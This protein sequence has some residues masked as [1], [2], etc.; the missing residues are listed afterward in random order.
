M[1]H[2]IALL[3]FV[4]VSFWFPAQVTGAAIIIDH[5]CADISQIPEQWITTAKN[6][7]RISYGH[8]SHGSQL[9]TGIDAIRDFKGSPFDFTYSYGYSAEIFL[10]DYVP[11]GDLGNPDRTTWAQETR[12]FLNQHGN[13]RNVVMWSW[14]GQVDGTAAEINTYLTLMNQLEQDF[15][16]VRFVYMTGHL[17]GSGDS[18]NVNLRNEQI[19]DYARNHHKI[20]FDFADIESYDP[21]KGVNYM[22]LHCDDNCDYDSDGNGSLDKNWALDWIADNPGSE[23][24]Q[25]AGQ[26]QDC[27]H[28]QKL[29]CVL[30][31]GA[32]WWLMARLVGWDGGLSFRPTLSVTKASTGTGII[33]S[34]PYGIDCG[35]TCNTQSALFDMGTV[36]TL[37]AQ[38]DPY[39]TFTGWSGG[40]C[41]G[42][43]DCIVTLTADTTVIATFLAQYDVVVQGSGN[44]SGTV[45]GNGITCFVTDGVA[46]GDC[47]E[48][49]LEGTPFTLTATP[50]P[51]SVFS[52]WSGGGCPATGLCELNLAGDT[53][54][55]AAFTDEGSFTK[56]TMVSPNGREKLPSGGSWTLVWGGPSTAKSYKLSYSLD[57]GIT[58]VPITTGFITGTSM[59]WT[60]PT[61]KKNKTKCLVKVEVFDASK[62]KLGSDKSD[63]SFTIQVL[64]ITGI[65]GGTSCH[66]G[67]TCPI[68]WKLA[69][70]FAPDQ[71]QVSY[72]LD[73]GLTWKKEPAMSMPPGSSY[74]WT[75]PT[76]K[77]T[78]T[79]EVKLTFKLAG[80]TVATAT[81]PKFTI[82]VP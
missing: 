31:G 30:K 71:L 27:A 64:T 55:T 9:V 36:I 25:I 53:T 67:T 1:V 56:V 62:K 34:L 51:G 2:R 32:F 78:K 49:I 18:G 28:S 77:K 61:F 17:N 38:A 10:N 54:I 46:G 14:C 63:R 47:R 5:N 58:W 26:C 65:N 21:D 6:N 42:T 69:D 48:T 45:S 70:A 52:G 81:S 76:V 13:D 29:N 75:A 7:L 60:V 16:S 33:T 12:D 80:A 24:A 4:F 40:G 23:P 11:S 44:G 15:S 35:T 59:S 8:T 39:S 57:K 72:T 66:S 19:R 20:L 3:V 50:D 79:C 43:G 82:T 37:T 74:D 22:P 68:S 73:G 41:S